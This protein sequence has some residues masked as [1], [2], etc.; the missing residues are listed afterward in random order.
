MFILQ[1]I[2]GDRCPA[3]EVLGIYKGHAIFNQDIEMVL[4][5][6]PLRADTV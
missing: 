6:L 2:D 4:R 5:A 3:P 1:L